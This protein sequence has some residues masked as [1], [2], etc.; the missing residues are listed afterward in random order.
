MAIRK[1]P[2]RATKAITS[3]D[4]PKAVQ[5]L[6]ARSSKPAEGN[7]PKKPILIRF[8]VQLLERV[9]MAVKRRGISRSAWIQFTL[10]RAL[11]YGE[12]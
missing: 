6:I 9:D 1:K 2:S 10:S 12:G 11:D 5:E 7:A 3:R 8:D 4:D